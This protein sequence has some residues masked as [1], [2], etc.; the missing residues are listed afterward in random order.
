MAVTTESSPE[1]KQADGTVGIASATKNVMVRRALKFTY[2]QGSAAGDDTSTLFFHKLPP[3]QVFFF[4]K[5]SYIRYT[6]FGGATVLDVG[7]EAYTGM[8]G[9]TVVASPT[10]FDTDLD[11]SGQAGVFALGSDINTYFVEFNSKDG[12][13]IYGTIGGGT[14]AAGAVVEGFLDVAW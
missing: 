10:A 5:T 11:V 13:G 4:P 9:V 7:Y 2:T 12:V 3:G 1:Y 6:D 14:I 8:D